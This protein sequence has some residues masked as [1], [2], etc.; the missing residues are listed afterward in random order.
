VREGVTSD[1]AINP[2]EVQLGD[3]LWGKTWGIGAKSGVRAIR[4]R[5]LVS[6]DNVLVCP[7][8]GFPTSI[9]PI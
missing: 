3:F 5:T 2:G 8:Q 1:A 6:V 9:N 4:A 7:A